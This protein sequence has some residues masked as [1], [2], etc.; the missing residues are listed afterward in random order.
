MNNFAPSV[1][2]IAALRTQEPL[3]RCTWL[4]ITQQRRGQSVGADQ[5]ANFVYMPKRGPCVEPV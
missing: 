4:R 2:T 1:D 3:S 5:N